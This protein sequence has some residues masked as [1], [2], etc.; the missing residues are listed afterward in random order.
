M[1]E[2][3]DQILEEIEAKR[4]RLAHNIDQLESYVREKADVTAHF[5]RKPWAFMGGAIVAGFLLARIVLPGGSPN[6]RRH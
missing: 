5:S 3:S 1:A 6:R 2:T 4:E